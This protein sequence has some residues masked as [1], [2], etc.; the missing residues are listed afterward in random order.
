MGRCHARPTVFDKTL[1]I[2]S[3]CAMR[4]VRRGILQPSLP[5]ASTELIARCRN[6]SPSVW[7]RPYNISA[8]NNERFTFDGH[9]E[10]HALQDRQ[11]LSAATSSGQ[12]IGSATT[13]ISNAERIAF[14]CPH[15]HLY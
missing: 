11:L 12:R 8:F 3:D 1:R 9:S 10:V 6:V 14:V 13:R 2:S 15:T 7:I 4:F 5:S